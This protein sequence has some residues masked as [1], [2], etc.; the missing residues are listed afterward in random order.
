MPTEILHFK[1]IG[2]YRQAV[3]GES[4]YQE[5]LARAAENDDELFV[6]LF[7]EDHNKFDKNAVAVVYENDTVGYLSREDAVKY[8]NAIKALNHPNA[9]GTCP[10]QVIGGGEDK[11]Y[12]IVLDLDLNNLQI[13]KIDQV[14]SSMSST[15]APQ[16]IQQTTPA[17]SITPRSTNFL[18]W[19]FRPG[20]YRILRIIS[21]II[22]VIMV[23]FACT[24]CFGTFLK[25]SNQ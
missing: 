12:G 16:P 14:Q 1:P 10:A 15:P 18:S 17:A 24:L 9:I 22:L 3:K 19:F 21:F 25:I 4:N 13:E 5:H 6:D 2:K 7:L 20:A 23:C 8:R 11:S